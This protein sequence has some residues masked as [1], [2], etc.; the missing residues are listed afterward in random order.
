VPARP[1]RARVPLPSRHAAPP[2]PS[3]QRRPSHPDTPFLPSRQCRPSPP[4]SAG[5]GTTTATRRPRGRWLPGLP[6]SFQLPRC[7][8][9]L[10]FAPRVRGARPPPPSPISTRR[11]RRQDRDERRIAA[12]GPLAGVGHHAECS[13]RVRV[14]GGGIELSATN[15]FIN[16]LI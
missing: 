2:L 12:A 1:K 10:G 5:P 7:S 9:H 6:H 11:R 8:P 4:I 3:R 14:H 13:S 16:V 15:Y